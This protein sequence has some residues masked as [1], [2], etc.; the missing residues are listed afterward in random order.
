M[1]QLPDR[2]KEIVE[3]FSFLE[4]REKLEYLLE[5]SENLPP[6]PRWLEGKQADMDQ[7]HECMTPVFIYPERRDGR[8][9]FHF[10][11]PAESP[12]VRGF[13]SI[14]QQGLGWAAPEAVQAI[15]FDF[16]RQMGLQDVLSGQRLNG[17]SAML[18][19]LK[20]LAGGA[21]E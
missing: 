6:L 2:L 8:I 13:A 15:P 1:S 7:V 17:M 5:F 12:T 16:Y 3:D 4:G 19:H 10:D 20:N 14:L 21:G 18:A 11:I 9:F